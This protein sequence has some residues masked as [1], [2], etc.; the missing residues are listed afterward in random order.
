MFVTINDEKIDHI[1]WEEIKTSP[2]QGDFVCYLVH[3]PVGAQYKE[4]AQEK[5]AEIEDSR[6]KTPLY[7]FK[8]IEKIRQLALEKDPSAL[9][10]MG[11][12]HALGIAVQQDLKEAVS[13]YTQAI[14][15]GEPR[16]FSNLGWFYQSGYGVEKNL[17]KSF[18]LI[19][20]GAKGGVLSA[21]AAMGMMLIKGEG[22]TQDVELGLLQ[23][24]EAFQ[25]GY[26][27]AG[28]HIAD[29]YF[30]GHYVSRDIEEGHR[31]LYHV[32]NAG[33]A[34]TMAILGHYL[35]TGVHGKTNVKEGLS[36]L[37]Q[38][39]EKKFLSAYL[40][41]AALYKNGTG[42]P[43]DLEMARYWYEKGIQAGS[44]EC[45]EAL[46]QLSFTQTETLH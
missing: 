28:N 7:Y 13:W 46:S 1:I 27:N 33:D 39:I 4:K 16:A 12:I 30:A 29:L 41:L 35:V 5:M 23:L 2:S 8:A 26:I 44:Q 14:E 15:A 19:S 21:K 45:Q 9:F 10:H 34:R 38:A 43:K 6:D 25:K 3:S 17:K 20:L 11:K 37:E 36:L 32:V 31:W 40:W 42:V 18:K 24:K 22:C